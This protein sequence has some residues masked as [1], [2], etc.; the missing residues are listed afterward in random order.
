[1]DD[2][3]MRRR[4]DEAQ[5]RIDEALNILRAIQLSDA[6]ARGDLKIVVGELRNAAQAL[7]TAAQRFEV[8]GLAAATSDSGSER[9]PKW[10]VY[11]IL[12]LVAIIAALVGVKA[13]GLVP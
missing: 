9:V 6:E 1:L 7:A 4:F 10:V 12:G 13:A 2:F 8:K 11:V 5:E 3:E